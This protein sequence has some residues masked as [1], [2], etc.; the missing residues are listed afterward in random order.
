[1]SVFDFSERH[2]TLSRRLTSNTPLQA[3]VLLDD[4][5]YMEAYRVLAT[6]VMK[7]KTAPED[8]VGLIFRLATRRL[9]IEKEKALFLQYYESE[10][11]RFT[12]DKKKAAEVVHI[13]VTSVDE[14][15]DVARLAA[16]TNVAAAVM[17][18][19][20]AYSIH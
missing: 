5:Q 4:P 17:N 12:Q 13:G 1:M 6:R 3:L 2:A 15:L 10:I 19:P 14:S 7:E 8:Q 11:A 9:P 20:D 18:T 16:L